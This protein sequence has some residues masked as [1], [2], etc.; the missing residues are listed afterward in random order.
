MCA[1]DALQEMLLQSEKGIIDLF[2]AIPDEWQTKKLSFRNFRAEGGV[3]ISAELERGNVTALKLES[4]R[5]KEV[6]IRKTPYLSKMAEERNWKSEE[7]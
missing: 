6:R 5:S 4:G 3:L 7:N 1:A 2:P